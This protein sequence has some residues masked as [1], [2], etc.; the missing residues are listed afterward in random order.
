MLLPNKVKN[1]KE[2]KQFVDTLTDDLEKIVE[3]RDAELRSEIQV[4]SDI[5]DLGYLEKLTQV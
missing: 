4:V 1:K 5:N 2:M 3:K